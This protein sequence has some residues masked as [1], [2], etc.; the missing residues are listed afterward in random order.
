MG[1]NEQHLT[2]IPNFSGEKCAL[3]RQ[4]MTVREV[5][6]ILNA[7]PN[8]VSSVNGQA[9]YT[10]EYENAKIVVVTEQKVDGQTLFNEALYLKSTNPDITREQAMKHFE[11]KG[12]FSRDKKIVAVHNCLVCTTEET[13]EG[14]SIRSCSNYSRFTGKCNTLRHWSSLYPLPG[15]GL[16]VKAH[17]AN[18]FEMTI[19]GSSRDVSLIFNFW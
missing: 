11:G 5:E 1:G 15:Q 4:G 14:R 13:L 18:L 16:Q 10:W 6:K 2:E 9:E 3:I 7:P 17:V 12:I 19:K 8:Q